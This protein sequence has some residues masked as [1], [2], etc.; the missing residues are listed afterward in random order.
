M[1]VDQ[2]YVMMLILSKGERTSLGYQ[3]LELVKGIPPELGIQ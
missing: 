2:T 3:V 1:V